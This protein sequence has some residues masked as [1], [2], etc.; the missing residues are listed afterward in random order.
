MVNTEFGFTPRK[1]L[2]IIL[3]ILVTIISFIIAYYIRNSFIFHRFPTLYEL[4]QYLWILW[5]V[6]PSWPIIFKRMGL[7]NGVL[8][9][10]LSELVYALMRAVVV[11]A[12]IITT[13]IFA[14]DDNLFSRLLFGIFIIVNFVLLLAEKII[15]RN[16]WAR[17]Q[18]NVKD[19]Q[20]VLVSNPEGV[21][22][23]TNLVSKDEDIRLK[24]LGYFS[25]NGDQSYVD[26]IS[27][28]GSLKNFNH[29]L[30][31][32]TVDEVIFVLP[33]DYIS[34]MEE[35]IV[36]CEELGITVRMLLDL[37]DLKISKT[38]ISYMGNIPMLIFHTVSLNED[39]QFIKRL[40]DIF[41]SLIG[42]F[43]TG[44]LYIILGPIIKL[45]S[46]GPVLYSQ[47]R[48]GRNGRIFK[49]YKFR[50]MYADADERKKELEHLNK[51]KG[52][53]FKIENDPRITPIGKIIRKYSLD[54]FPQFWNVLKGEMSLVGT[55]PPTVDEVKQYENRHWRRLSIKPGI[56]GL[57]QV[58][59]RNNIEDFDEIVALDV[60]YIDNWSI[61]LDLKIIAKTVVAVFKKTGV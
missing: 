2:A 59:G 35:Y 55:R 22:K 30:I 9:A 4:E 12:L 21:F 43:I 26:G 57:W 42:L 11:G 1:K 13:A 25:I 40:I 54:E 23:F 18:K 36:T 10:E 8:K 52:A 6:V 53:I 38:Q 7:Y 3:D 17:A 47:P 56:T 34:D 60:K 24:I 41:V 16:I 58:S 49:C 27:C 51:M 39:Q 48:V 50:S 19:R 61:W 37:Y 31:Q 44:I 29:F 5:V 32:K 14:A 28:L 45:Q 15:L 46:P 33:K 20:V